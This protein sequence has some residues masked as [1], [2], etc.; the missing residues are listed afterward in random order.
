[1]HLFL[2]LMILF[3]FSEV[4]SIQPLIKRDLQAVGGDVLEQFLIDNLKDRKVGYCPNPGNAGDALIW[5]GTICLFKKLGISH[6]PYYKKSKPRSK[7]DVIVFGGGGNLI[8]YYDHCSTFLGKAMKTGKPLI[9]LPHTI[10]GHETLLA[11]LSPNV[12][13]FCREQMS[14]EYC[15]RIVPFPENLFLACDLAFYADMT[16]FVSNREEAKN[17]FAFRMDCEI[18]KMREGIRLPDTNLDISNSFGRI[19]EVSSYAQNYAML[20][21]FLNIINAHEVVWTDRLHV[22]IGAFLLGKKVHLFDNSYGK[23]RAVYESTIKPLDYLNQVEFHE[24]WEMFR[25]STALAEA[26]SG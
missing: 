9:L 15:Q 22:G 12:T 18:N 4:H 10:Q 21:K 20:E 1:M 25:D 19:T 8:P 24:D 13:L 6:V 14:Y 3:Q 2:L 17:L 26:F 16:P 11:N 23:I 5:Y 7:I